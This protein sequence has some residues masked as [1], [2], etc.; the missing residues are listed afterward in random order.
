M[1]KE[2]TK[3]VDFTVVD[4]PAFYNVIM[5]TPWLNALKAISSTYHLGIKFLTQSGVAAVW[6]CQK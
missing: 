3:I 5:G 1:A 4:H 6:G 2:V